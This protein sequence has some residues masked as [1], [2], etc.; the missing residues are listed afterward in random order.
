M[1]NQPEEVPG[2]ALT[3][4]LKILV[5]LVFAKHLAATPEATQKA[6]RGTRSAC[7]FQIV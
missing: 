7:R 6:F 3:F 2:M 1:V 5:T 4:F